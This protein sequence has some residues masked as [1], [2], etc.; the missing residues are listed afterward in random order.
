MTSCDPGSPSIPA[1][2][3][4]IGTPIDSPLTGLPPALFRDG[5]NLTF[6]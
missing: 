6:P 4:A 1:P 3:D 5:E 2:E